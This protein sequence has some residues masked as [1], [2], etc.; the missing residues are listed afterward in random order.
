MRRLRILFVARPY[1][2]HTARWIN[3]V[4]DLGWDL[5]LFP[6]SESPLHRDYRNITTYYFERDPRARLHESVRTRVLW[7][8]PFAGSRVKLLAN[9]LP[10]AWADRAQW[11]ARIIRRIKPDIV[12][13]LEFQEAGYLVARTKPLFAE[14]EF[15]PLIVS[16]WGSDIQLYGPLPE[17]TE[18]VKAVLAAADY[19]SSECERDVALA[20]EYG[21]SGEAFPALPASG[22]FDLENM[23]QYRQPGPTSAR[24]VVA[25]KGYQHWAGRALAGLRALELCADALNARG[26]TVAL[27]SVHNAD[28][29]LAAERAAHRA[30]L[31]IKITSSESR[32]DVLRTHGRA[33][34]SIGLSISDGL[35]TSALEGLIMGAF[36]VQSNTSCLMELLDG[37]ET[38]VMVPPEDP[39]EIAAAITRAV[40]D[41]ELVDR[42]VAINDRMVA[43]RLS[44]RVIRPEVVAMYE[45]V[46]ERQTTKN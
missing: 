37:Q 4:A 44:D 43:E 22:G 29:R 40:T 42:A 14:G 18:K 2:V 12:H 45:S 34:V 10:P 32:E 17:H 27:H 21:F 38:A 5:H 31:T 41:D 46:I 35:S 8:L 25:L 15:P 26:M 13:A 16:N 11:L 33:R 3:Q 39:R 19:Y 9:R 20:R 36:V 7:P 6:G 1:S 24:R 28:V 30:G 23:R